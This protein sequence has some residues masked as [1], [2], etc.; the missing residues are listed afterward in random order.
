MYQTH[1]E[2]FTVRNEI[3]NAGCGVNI[4]I[5]WITVNNGDN[6]DNESPRLMIALWSIH[7]FLPF[8][9]QILVISGNDEIITACGHDQCLGGVVIMPRDELMVSSVSI[10]SQCWVK[11]RDL[12]RRLQLEQKYC[13]HDKLVNLVQAMQSKKSSLHNEP[14]HTVE[15]GFT[16]LCR[17][18][19]EDLS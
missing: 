16:F 9:P 2:Q 1:W 18:G 13:T 10:Y 17:T 19:N 12:C 8:T 3:N 14:I 4:S 7:D 5:Q 15:P 11:N 6:N